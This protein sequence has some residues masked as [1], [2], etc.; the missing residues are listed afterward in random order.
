M[1]NERD[2]FFVAVNSVETEGKEF[3]EDG[4]QV[5]LVKNYQAMTVRTFKSYITE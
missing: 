4:G 5:L 1:I 2:D 3:R